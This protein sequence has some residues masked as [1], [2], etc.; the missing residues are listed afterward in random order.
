MVGELSPSTSGV[1]VSATASARPVLTFRNFSLRCDKSDPQ[2]SFQSPWDWELFEGRK[3]AFITRNLFLQYQLIAGFAGLV[4][5]VSGEMICTG[6]VSWPVGG[7]G[8]LDRKLKISHAFDFLCTVYADCLERS[9]V[10]VD[11]FWGI[12]LS[13]G[14]RPNLLIKELAKDQKEFFYLALSV[15][16]SFDCY[17]INKSKS[18]ALMSK[19]AEPLRV[20]FRRQI[21]GKSLI[22][23][24]TSKAFRSEFCT[25][26]LVLDSFGQILFSGDLAEAV[27]WADQNLEAP[28]VVESD[29]DL[30]EMGSKFKNS[31]TSG[32]S[33]D[34][35]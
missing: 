17:L 18:F 14:I 19:A 33:F 5:P 1:V 31:E 23:T 29:D 30:F 4:S 22:T 34:D 15:L 25:D 2:I 6:S 11:E 24:S 32:D 8:G 9:R 27:Q 28:A 13:K 7:E 20:L 21:E 16:F 26:G 12:L 3:I 35:F 10:G